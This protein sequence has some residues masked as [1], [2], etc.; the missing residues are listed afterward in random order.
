MKLENL[1]N[2]TD[3]SWHTFLSSLDQDYLLSLINLI[4]ENEEVLAP[5]PNLVFKVLRMPLKDIK[6]V[7]LGQDPYHT[8]D[9]ATGLSFATNDIRTP[10]LRQI[11]AELASSKNNPFF[12]LDYSLEDWNKQGVFLLNCALTTVEG[13]AGQHT[14]EWKLFTT[15]LIKFITYNT[16][17]VV[18]MLWGNFAKEKQELITNTSHLVLTHS[19][20]QAANFNKTKFPFVGCNHFTEANNY[21]NKYGIKGIQW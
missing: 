8:K 21:F 14:K 4:E 11:E 6:V 5:K 7:I 16:T 10:S 19:H 2:S 1:F 20:P 18:W 15:E 17:N 12:K 9:V 3:E 13:T